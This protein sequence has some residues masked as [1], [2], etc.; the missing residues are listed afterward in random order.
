MP[1]INSTSRSWAAASAEANAP[2][3]IRAYK[4]DGGDLAVMD[5]FCADIRTEILTA[6]GWRRYDE[7]A[8]GDLVASLNLEDGIA[9]WVPVQRMNVFEVADAKMLRVEGRSLSAL[10]TAGHRWPVQ[11]RVGKGR[12]CR[13]EWQIRTSEQITLGSAVVRS[14]PF[15]TPAHA[16][17]SDALVELV[18][19]AWTEGA[20]RKDGGL[21]ISQSPA[22][23]PAKCERIE[24]ALT[25][26]TAGPR[27]A[28]AAVAASQPG[29]RARTRAL[30][31]GD[32]TGLP[33]R[34]SW[35]PPQ[36]VSSTRR[37]C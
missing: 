8:I 25:K 31:T 13:T 10:V 33:R 34:P 3:R 37:G 14:A 29:T 35:L 27:L 36:I 18:G 12:S 24:K 17:Q 4:H 30:G 32:S 2:K 21:H 19:W 28:R 11:Q 15:E 1:Y 23:N 16:A 22:V 9:R 5:W 26:R 20:I 7:V 6:N